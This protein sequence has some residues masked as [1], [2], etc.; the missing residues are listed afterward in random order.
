MIGKLDIKNTKRYFLCVISCMLIFLFYECSAQFL[1]TQNI[2][3][4]RLFR[5]TIVALL[6][7]LISLRIIQLS[8]IYSERSKADLQTKL[9]ALQSRIEPHFLFNSLNTI[10][11]LTH[12]NPNQAESAIHSL[13]SILR[14]NLK[15][16]DAFHSVEEEVELCQKYTELESFRIGDRL[17]ANVKVDPKAKDA[18]IPKLI[19]QPLIENAVRHGISPFKNG[20]VIELT[21]RETNKRIICSIINKIHN[22]ETIPEEHHKQ[23]QGHG[24][25]INNLRERLFVIYDHRY[26][27]KASQSKNRYFVELTIPSLP[28][29]NIALKKSK[30][31]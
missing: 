14:S 27:I 18:I 6:F 28:P 22:S 1:Y 24:I 5:M 7:L 31:N 16:D 4:T 19:I 15:D 8:M 12:I 30:N 2:D 17:Q 20:G 13:S 10:A 9:N 29:T 26:H 25:A 23:L 3:L 21:I 11:E